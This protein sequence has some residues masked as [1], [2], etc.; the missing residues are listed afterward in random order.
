MNMLTHM[1]PLVKANDEARFIQQYTGP[2]LARQRNNEVDS[3][4][5][6]QTSDRLPIVSLTQTLR[7]VGYDKKAVSS[8][9]RAISFASDGEF[10]EGF[11]VD[12]ICKHGRNP[13]AKGVTLGRTINNDIVISTSTVSKFHAWIQKEPS[14]TGDVYSCFDAGSSFGTFVNEEPLPS[15]HGCLLRPGAKIRLGD[16]TLTFLDALGTYQWIKIRLTFLRKG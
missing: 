15:N 6:F 5:S 8:G 12:E 1:L 3:P 13:F 4:S 14:P 7:P 2:F 10:C 16:V 11:S 9:T